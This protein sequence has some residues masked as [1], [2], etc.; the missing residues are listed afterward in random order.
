MKTLTPTLQML[1]K[2]TWTNCIPDEQI[3]KPTRVTFQTS[4]RFKLNRS[5]QS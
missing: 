5:F 4:L 2:W 3:Y 1:D